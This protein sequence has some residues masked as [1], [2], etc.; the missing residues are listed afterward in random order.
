M[1]IIDISDRLS[2]QTPGEEQ[3]VPGAVVEVGR[4][5]GCQLVR[6]LEDFCC[7]EC[8][9]NFGEKSGLLFKRIRDDSG[10]A[11]AFFTALMPNKRQSF[12]RLFGLPPGCRA[13]AGTPTQDSRPQLRVVSAESTQCFPDSDS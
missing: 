12:I 1:K 9:E 7:S 5:A 10:F 4:C 13:P 11:A 8:R 2:K 3:A 6:K